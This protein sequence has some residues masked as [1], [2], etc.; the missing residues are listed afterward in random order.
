[1]SQE[2]GIMMGNLIEGMTFNEE[3]SQRRGMRGK[4]KGYGKAEDSDPL[5]TE[6]FS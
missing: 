3:K 4:R 6:L 5:Q 1:M 2:E